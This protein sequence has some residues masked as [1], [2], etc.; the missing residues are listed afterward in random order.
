VKYYLE[1]L[2]DLNQGRIA[3]VY[4][5]FGPEGYLRREA[6]KR[7]RD[8]IIPGAQNDLNFISLDA[9]EVSISDILS[10]ASMTPLFADK[11][12]VLVKNSN[13]FNRK[14]NS[15]DL[16][17]DGDTA[18]VRKDEAPLLSYIAG[19]NPGTCLVFDAGEEIDKRKKV[20]KEIAKNGKAIEFTLLKAEEL[21]MWL[22]KQAR[23]AGKTLAPGAASEILARAGNNLQ[24]LWVEINKLITYAGVNKVITV[25]DVACAT[26]PHPEE[27]VFA[28]VDAIGE[29]NASRAIAG[30]NRLLLQKHPPP[31]ILVMVARQI[32]LILRAG[33]AIRSGNQI[34]ELSQTLGIHPFVAKKIAAQQKNFNRDQLI[35]WLLNLHELDVTVKSGKQEFLPGMEALIINICSKGAR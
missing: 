34:R 21:T 2:E 24:C 22:E 17:E 8:V 19:P 10:M 23:L 14:K 30:I 20:Y 11:R 16:P 29:R 25:D 9:Q 15:G 32:R 35:R 3:P 18:S 13:L 28:V 6:V 12:L 33:E 27:D 31:A 4:L 1:L 7:M 5:F 26:P